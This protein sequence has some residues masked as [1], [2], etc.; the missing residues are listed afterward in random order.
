MYVYTYQYCVEN[1]LSLGENY[2]FYPKMSSLTD[3]IV[4]YIPY[5][6]IKFYNTYNSWTP[7]NFK[8]IICSP[9][10]LH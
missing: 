6:I 9:S 4:F 5:T 8:A 1:I 7:A 3:V 10:A 2:R